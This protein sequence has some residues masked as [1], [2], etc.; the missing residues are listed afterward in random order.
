MLNQKRIMVY[1][2]RIVLHQKRIQQKMENY[3]E[4]NFVKTILVVLN[5][6]FKTRL[7]FKELNYYSQA[8]KFYFFAENS[9]KCAILASDTMTPN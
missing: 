2:K 8:P 5:T 3:T 7:H 9:Q 6:V 4:A 1:R